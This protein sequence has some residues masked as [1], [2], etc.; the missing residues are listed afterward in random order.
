MK[1][2]QRLVM[3]A[4]AAC[5][6]TSST[7]LAQSRP[8]IGF[9]YPAGGQQGTTFR[10]RLA[11]QNMGDLN[12][13]A[14]SG[15]GVTARVVEYLRPLGP[16][17]IGLLYQ[18]QNELRKPKANAGAAM[19]M[20][21]SE[22][23]MMASAATLGAMVDR[24]APRL[25]AKLQ[26]RVTE[27]CNQPTTGALSA[28]AFIEVTI[29]PDAS[30]GERE[31]RLVT[32]RGGAS[33]PLPFHVGQVPEYCRKPMVTSSKQ[34]LGKEYLALRKR[35]ETEIED[36]IS[37]PCTVNGQIA[38]GEMNRYR[39]EA[40]KGQRLVITTLARQLIP[41]IA[42]A[43]P[44]WFQPV[45]ALYD[46]D[47][48]E[49]AYNDD[50]RFKPDPIIVYEVPKDGEYILAVADAIFRGREDFVYR[51][52]IGEAPFVTSVF[53]LG[54]RAGE[55]HPIKMTGVNLAD[56]SL[57]PVAAD[58]E[59]GIQ[60]VAANKKGF[61]SNRVPFALD[62]LPEIL[63]KESNN[64]PSRAQKIALPVIVNGL[65]DKKDDWDVFQFNGSAGDMVVAEVM[66]RRLDSP[67]DSVI[68]LTDAK[69]QLLAFSDD[70]E[71]LGSGLNT[72]HADSY[73]MA[74]LPANGTYYVHV[75]DSARKG[76]EEFGYRLR[77]SPPRPDFE[78]RTMTSSASVRMKNSMAF[79]VFALR[80]DGF[81]EP[82]KLTLK[83]LPP[84]LTPYPATLATNKNTISVGF[85]ADVATTNG[86]VNAIIIG[87]AKIGDKEVVH[88]AVPAEDRMQAFLWRHLVPARELKVL[89]YDPASVLPP[90]YVAP[91]LPLALLPRAKAVTAEAEAAG[92]KITKGQVAGRVSQL[93]RL[94]EEG[95][96]TTSFYH[97]RIVECGDPQ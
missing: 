47:G 68:K 22:T 12:G 29:A 57:I 2:I 31:L 70:R 54:G 85:K 96:F 20:M 37:I 13:V 56:A 90:K 76:G 32:L 38:N 48:K 43:V 91:D 80:K 9:A 64:T 28:L 75:G 89:V 60:Q 73:F 27:Y 87:T 11:G 67:V 52:T 23:P 49:L 17:D 30:P 15:A 3:L 97:D 4:V 81:N 10:V 65:I 92:R 93:R 6:A 33:N 51:V 21:S 95:L 39:F 25:M 79:I 50:Y 35:P 71:D 34:I 69:G 1:T 63:D 8:Y 19:M 16:I 86:P 5:L 36:R 55:T 24:S 74:K 61:I 59:P 77:I 88:Q 44:G 40:R 72:H 45:L 26:K 84:G 58:A 53:P 46:A 18:Q 78:L 14:V 82:I 94:Y 42:D 66:A 83:N 62:T 7:V 41:Y